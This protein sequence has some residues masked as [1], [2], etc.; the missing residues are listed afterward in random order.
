M[1]LHQQLTAAMAHHQAGRFGEAERLYRE[2]LA[3]SPDSPDAL[4]L[5]GVLRAERVRT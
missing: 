1:N 4:H 2:A 3:T 5:L